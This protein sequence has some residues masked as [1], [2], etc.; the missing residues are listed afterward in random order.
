MKKYSAIFFIPVLIC[1]CF[2]FVQCKKNNS[3]LKSNDPNTLWDKDTTTIERAITGKWKW[4]IYGG[5]CGINGASYLSNTVVNITK[6]S[7]VITGDDGL[8]Q[9][10]SYSWKKDKVSLGYTTYVIWNNKQNRGEWFFD[11]IQNDSLFIYSYSLNP[12]GNSN[13]YL[14]TLIK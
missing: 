9:A 1:I 11:E 3:T 8:N 10:F 12:C 4:V 7:V 5:M 2:A 13:S 14:F 6:D